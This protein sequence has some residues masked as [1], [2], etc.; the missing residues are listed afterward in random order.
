[1][2]SCSSNKYVGVTLIELIITIIIVAI[3]SA[4]VVN[5]M[6]AQTQRSVVVQV[7]QL[8][9]NLSHLQLLA[10]SRGMSVQLV[11]SMDQL[12]QYS[13]SAYTCTTITC[14]SKTPLV[15][16]S[17]GLAFNVPL[18]DKVVISPV[19]SLNFDSLG[20]PQSGGNLI[21]TVPAITYTLSGS[22][23]CAKVK[24]LPITGFSFSE[25]PYGC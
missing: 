4:V 25:P 19:G 11:V 7:D 1:M 2:R 5:R 18:T 17:T 20:R 15:D 9:R 12:G 14:S 8:R 16:P 3:L 13:Y 24:V 21:S 10:I 23:N 6:S 22:Q